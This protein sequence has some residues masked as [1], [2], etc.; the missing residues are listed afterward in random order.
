M[1][2]AKSAAKSVARYPDRGLPASPWPRCEGTIARTGHGRNGNTR[3]LL[4]YIED[5]RIRPLLAGT[6]RLSDFHRAQ[7]DFMAKSF[8]GKLVVVPDSK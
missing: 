3:R 7:T 5:G 4:G 8:V 2:D 1:S 6:C